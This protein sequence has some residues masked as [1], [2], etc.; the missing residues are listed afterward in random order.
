[1]APE[2]TLCDATPNTL[3]ILCKF[4]LIRGEMRKIQTS[5]K[6]ERKIKMITQ[7]PTIE[8]LTTNDFCCTFFK[9]YCPLDSIKYKMG[10]ASQFIIAFQLIYINGIFI[11]RINNCILYTT[12]Y[13]SVDGVYHIVFINAILIHLYHVFVCFIFSLLINKAAM[14]Y[15]LARVL[16]TCSMI[17]F[18]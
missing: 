7:N 6:K 17:F 1:M 2:S 15:H 18:L 9:A 12:E 8:M 13:S 11:F 3:Y 4:M 16:N 5:L 14:H 10:Y